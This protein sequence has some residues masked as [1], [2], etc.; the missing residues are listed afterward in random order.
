VVVGGRSPIRLL[1]ETWERT[2]AEAGTALNP[3]LPDDG[4]DG[5]VDGA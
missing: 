2:F 4:F 5:A 1:A 3:A